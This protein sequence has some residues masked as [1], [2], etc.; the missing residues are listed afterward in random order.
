MRLMPPDR[1]LEKLANLENVQHANVGSWFSLAPDDSPLV[2]RDMS[3]S[4][5]YA[6]DREAP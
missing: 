6:L 1:N 3:R 2:I 4:E 5:I